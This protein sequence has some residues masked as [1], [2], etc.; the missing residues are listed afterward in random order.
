ML[1]LPLLLRFD[2]GYRYRLDG[3]ARVDD[4]DCYVVRF[5]PLKADASLTICDSVQGRTFETSKQLSDNLTLAGF[6]K[7]SVSSAAANSFVE[8]NAYA[9]Q[10]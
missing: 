7:V 8:V 2:E 6:I 1:S 3:T 4:H 5:E 9:T 10:L